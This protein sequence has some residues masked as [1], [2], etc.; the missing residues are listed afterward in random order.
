MSLRE[1][2]GRGKGGEGGREGLACEHREGVWPRERERQQHLRLERLRTKNKA[3]WSAAAG[4]GTAPG[5]AG[6]GGVRRATRS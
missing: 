2:G 3:A 5:G 4:G 1:G 6:R